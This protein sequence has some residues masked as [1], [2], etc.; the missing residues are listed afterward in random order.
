MNKKH[1]NI[2]IAIITIVR[3]LFAI[4]DTLALG[5]ELNK[6]PIGSIII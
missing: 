5:D 3:I 2:I 1:K 4:S 6:G